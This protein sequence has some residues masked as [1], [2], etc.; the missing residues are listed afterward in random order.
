MKRYHSVKDRS[1]REQRKKTARTFG[2][3]WLIG[4]QNMNSRH[5]LDC[6]RK[7]CYICHSDK[8]FGYTKPRD[9]REFERFEN[10]VYEE[11]DH[12]HEYDE[13]REWLNNIED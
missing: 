13:Y 3:E 8:L 6:G 10:M 5:P 1:K 7:R 2:M 11:F 9:Y 12:D 4:K